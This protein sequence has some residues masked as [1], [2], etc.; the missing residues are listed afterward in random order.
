[1]SRL[2][3]AADSSVPLP[4]VIYAVVFGIGVT[5]LCDGLGRYLSGIRATL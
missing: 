4:S 1:M 3:A 2:F 5:L